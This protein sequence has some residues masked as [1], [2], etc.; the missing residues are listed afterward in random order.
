MNQMKFSPS[1]WVLHVAALAAAWAVPVALGAAAPVEINRIEP[2]SAWPLIEPL[3]YDSE[4]AVE[5]AED[6][7]LWAAWQTYRDGKE[8]ILARMVRNSRQG[9]FTLV[10]PREGIHGHPQIAAFGETEAWV[11]WATCENGRWS[12]RARR[13]RDDVAGAV[14]TVSPPGVDAVNPALCRWG[15]RGVLVAWQALV[16]GRMT[17]QARR[18]TGEAWTPVVTVSGTDAEAFRPAVVEKGGGQEAWVFWDEYRDLHYT[19]RGRRVTPEPGPIER[20][21]PEGAYAVKV[22][23]LATPAGE[24]WATWVHSTDVIGG[25]AVIDQSNAAQVAVRRDG[26]WELVRDNDGGAD[27]A[28]L[29]YGLLTRM[30][31]KP[32]PTGGYLG[33]RRRPLLLHDGAAVWV[34]WERKSDETGSTPQVEGELVGRRYADGRWSGLQTLHA[35]GV[36]YRPGGAH[37]REGAW[38]FAVSQLPRESRRIY[39]SVAVMPA[40]A[41]SARD[42]RPGGW[43]PVKLPLRARPAARPTIV[44]AGRTLRLYWL[45]SHVHSALSADA[46]GEPDEILHYAR[47]RAQL[48]VVVM[49]END[50]MYDTSLTET[51]Y[52][53][54]TWLSRWISARGPL[55]ALPGFEWTQ[56]LPSDG[57]DRARP[58]FWRSS[59]RNH[60]TVIYPLRGGPVLRYPEVENDI[61]R[62]YAAVR[63]A[64]GVMH[65]QHETFLLAAEPEEAAIEVTAGWGIYFLN[66]GRIHAA[67]NAGSRKAFI[68]T[69]DSHRRNPGLGGGLTGIYA[70]DSSD[71][72]ILEAYRDRRM[73][74]TT[75]SRVLIEARLNGVLMG[76][77]VPVSGPARLDLRVDSPRTV[78]R[79]VLVR[80]GTEIKSF[81]GEGRRELQLGHEDATSPGKTTWYYWRIELDGPGTN[82]RGNAATA[83][84]NLAWSSPLWAVRP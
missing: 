1:P 28:S 70:E 74:A 36:D 54:G 84:G 76:R 39:E 12:V 22:E 34:A 53:L 32:V 29:D 55:L 18:F 81:P 37:A 82:Y 68:G 25:D 83:E 45:D 35:G 6:G 78:K 58:R 23:P 72:K 40:K 77:D 16:D 59:F 65:T 43:A 62:L 80:D 14:E 27:V 50:H 73:F 20:V 48:D 38:T 75:G 21:S 66:P 71:T 41:T 79:V 69:S 46:E 52:A 67:L 26:R 61:G 44:E 30:A 63:Q 49:Q 9:R 2:I 64:G 33:E 19:V 47:D 11:G 17:I 60:R 8:A 4:M 51:E 5:R 15:G 10:T 24:L 56:M 31:P 57:A 13:I 42:D 7:A 3:T